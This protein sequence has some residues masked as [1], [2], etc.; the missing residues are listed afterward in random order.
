M[1][2]QLDVDNT[3]TWAPG[4]FAWMSQALKRD[5]HRVAIVTARGLLPGEPESTEKQLQG[6]GLVW[7]DLILSEP[8][9]EIDSQELP[10]DYPEELLQLWPKLKATMRARP[11]LVFDDSE[12]I[13]ALFARYMPDIKV[14]RP[15][16][17]SLGRG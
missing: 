15:L 13:S 2:I 4:F 12:E 11:D 6:L 7:D 10:A 16:S 5:G 3:I 17:V 14:M 9:P 8:V 1:L